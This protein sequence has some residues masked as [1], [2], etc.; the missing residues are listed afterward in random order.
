MVFLFL[1]AATLNI[2]T[3]VGLITLVG[4]ITKHGILMVD[5]ANRMQAEGH[6]VRAAIEHAAGVRLRPILMTTAAM[7]LG[8]S[9]L[10][11]AQGPGAEARFSMGLV[12]AAGMAIGTLFTLFVVP[13][14]YVLVASNRNR[15]KA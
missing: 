12:I 15:R 7:V 10:L 1:G 2:Y 9:P 11:I 8:V 4:L 14:F 13:A 3:Q 5:F 6:A